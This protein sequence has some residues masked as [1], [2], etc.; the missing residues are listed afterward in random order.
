MRK[1]ALWAVIAGA[2]A[3][4]ACAPPEPREPPH[5]L[6]I[7]VD[8]LRADH[9][10]LYGYERDTTPH[11]RK[12]AREGTIFAR[13]LVNAP[14]TKPSVASILT[15]LLPPAHGSQWGDFNRVA[16]GAVDVLAESFETLPEVLQR[17]GYTTVAMMTNTTIT[18]EIGYAQGF[19]RFEQIGADLTSDR[20]S[21]LGAF[22]ALNAA[23]GPTF[24]WCH[25]MAPHNY[26]LPKGRKRVFESET[27]TPILRREYYGPKMWNSYGF[28]FREPA[29]DVY[30]ETVRWVDQGVGALVRRVRETHPNTL[31]LF[32]S[33]HGEEFGEH[34]GY[35]HARTLH[36]EIL[37]VPLVMWGPGVPRGRVVDELSQSIDLLPT[38][39]DVVGVE[40]PAE[41]Q[42]RSLLSGGEDEPIVYAEKRN[43]RNL[44]RAVLTHD[45][46][47]LE[48]QPDGTPGRK[49]AK[50][51]EGTWHYFEDP[52]GPDRESRLGALAPDELTRRQAR[53][54]AIWS[55]SV[56][57]F[58]ARTGGE[59]QRA[60]RDE[61]IEALRALGYVDDEASGDGPGRGGS[62]D[63]T[64]QDP[65]DEPV[66]G[67]SS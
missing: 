51:D 16:E 2:L 31:I 8:T 19:D 24:V 1:V 40:P 17:H 28:R 29:I 61:E 64:G 36:S 44:M 37:H 26:V 18:P 6:L 27:R 14:W 65:G 7:V 41:V 21:V 57:L 45:G 11:L 67:A 58:E 43:G 62:G 34:G 50:G 23:S 63:E 5:V 46:K 13:H 59:S 35:L 12:L 53:L 60:I 39:L 49:P 47:L 10:S 9:T 55:D 30:D 25:V 20:R 33:D 56:A 38:V 3:W 32:T 42:G 15:G 54:E 22:E 48:S 66:G 4:V 52:V